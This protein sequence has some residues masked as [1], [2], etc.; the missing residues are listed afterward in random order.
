MTF[1]SRGFLE[2]LPVPRS[3]VQRHLKF[4]DV[5]GTCIMSSFEGLEEGQSALQIK[6]GTPYLLFK[7]LD[8]QPTSSG[9]FG[10]C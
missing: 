3:P 6:C 2:A 5:L 8:H 9:V 7:Q 10:G 4:S 1:S